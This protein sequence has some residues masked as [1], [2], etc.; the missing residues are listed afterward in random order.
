MKKTILLFFMM[1]TVSLGAVA[2]NK[3][4]DREAKEKEFKEFKIKFLADQL[5][6]K[7]DVRQKFNA[8]YGEY[9]NE[10]RVLFKKKKEIEKSIKNGKKVTEAEYDRANKELNDIKTQSAALE[11][12][13]DEKFS[14]FLSKEQIFNL[15]KSEEKFKENMRDLKEKKKKE[16]KK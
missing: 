9:E 13:Y 10:R 15:K 4:C 7:G 2:Q 6:L 5:N 12:T 11:K 1:V 14:K 3:G 16:Q 8:V